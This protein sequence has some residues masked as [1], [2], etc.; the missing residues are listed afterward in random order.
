[1]CSVD[2][3][4]MKNLSLKHLTIPFDSIWFAVQQIIGVDFAWNLWK[5][6]RVLETL[7]VETTPTN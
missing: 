1:M 5:V 2:N 7:D 6:L 4:Y 3:I